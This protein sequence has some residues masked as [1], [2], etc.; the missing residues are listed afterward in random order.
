[1]AGAPKRAFLDEERVQMT[2]ALGELGFL[3]ART[4]VAAK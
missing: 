3:P 4:S 2:S 1:M